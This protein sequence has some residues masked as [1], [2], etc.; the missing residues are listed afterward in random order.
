ML[1]PPN[2]NHRL[3]CCLHLETAT[4]DEEPR[5]TTARLVEPI[6]L[7]Q[8]LSEEVE[9]SLVLASNGSDKQRLMMG[10]IHLQIKNHPTNAVYLMEDTFMKVPDGGLRIYKAGMGCAPRYKHWLVS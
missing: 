5:T 9:T 8:L 4:E 2:C 3:D 6:D 7:P 10:Q 1:I